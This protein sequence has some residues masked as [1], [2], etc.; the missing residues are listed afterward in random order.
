MNFNDSKNVDKE[1]EITK[2]VL[3]IHVYPEYEDVV[4][5]LQNN[6]EMFSEYVREKHWC[7]YYIWDFHF[8]HDDIKKRERKSMKGVAFKRCK[9][10]IIQ[11]YMFLE[12]CIRMN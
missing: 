5:I 2:E 3:N 6:M 9:Q 12:L 4:K 7:M 1:I 11:C 10:I 8:E